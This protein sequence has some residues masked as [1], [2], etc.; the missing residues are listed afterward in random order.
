MPLAGIPDLNVL[1]AGEVTIPGGMAALAAAAHFQA[2]PGYRD[3]FGECCR[4]LIRHTTPAAAASDAGI[5]LHAYAR[6]LESY[7]ASVAELSRLAG[8]RDDRGA[9]TLSL[10]TRESRAMTEKAL[11]LIG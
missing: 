4:R 2:E 7:F 3:F 1:T 5:D 8:L 10:A 6:L 11:A 9:L